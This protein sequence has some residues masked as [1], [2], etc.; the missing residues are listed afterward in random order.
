MGHQSGLHN[1]LRK[2]NNTVS[3]SFAFKVQLAT[4][5]QVDSELQSCHEEDFL[6]NQY[7][8]FLNF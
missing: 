3:L 4:P 6:K 5:C 8:L 7:I 1:E 2:V